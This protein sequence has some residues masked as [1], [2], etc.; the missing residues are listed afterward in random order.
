VSKIV[1]SDREMR[2]AVLLRTAKDQWVFWLILFAITFGAALYSFSSAL[3]AAIV[4][5]IVLSINRLRRGRLR[6]SWSGVVTVAVINAFALAA[7]FFAK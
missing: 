2:I 5:V 7:A 1:S 4:A 6:T 3:V